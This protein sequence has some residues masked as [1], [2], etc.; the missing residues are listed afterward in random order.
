MKFFRQAEAIHRADEEAQ[1]IRHT[2]LRRA[3]IRN[4]EAE[5]LFRRY[6]LTGVL[7]AALVFSQM[8]LYPA[9]SPPAEP[10]P[11]HQLLKQ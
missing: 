5:R 8:E 6:V 7:P 1:T 11:A 3:A 2:E 10:P 9:D 4:A